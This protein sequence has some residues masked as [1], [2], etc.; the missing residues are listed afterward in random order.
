MCLW[1]CACKRTCVSAAACVCAC[2]GR[3]CVQG[4]TPWRRHD[5]ADHVFMAFYDYGPC[6]CAAKHR[7]LCRAPFRASAPIR[8]LPAP[9]LVCDAA[10][11]LTAASHRVAWRGVAWHAESRSIAS[12]FVAAK[13]SQWP[14]RAEPSCAGME[15]LASA[16]AREGVPPIILRAHFL[17]LN[18]DRG[19]NPGRCYRC[20]A[21]ALYTTRCDETAL[22][23]RIH[24]QRVL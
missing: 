14:R 9:P 4:I 24:V 1:A 17:V 11:L 7:F 22:H 15:F 18:G 8:C 5:G 23:R 6:E 2:C 16:A 13:K 20:A 10:E 21:A 3:M 12:A 19:A